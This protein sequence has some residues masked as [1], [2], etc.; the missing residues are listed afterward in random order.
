MSSFFIASNLIKF[1]VPLET[2]DAFDGL[3]N[4]EEESQ[5]SLQPFYESA[6]RI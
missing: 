6:E 4:P 2:V 3:Q 5:E 1:S